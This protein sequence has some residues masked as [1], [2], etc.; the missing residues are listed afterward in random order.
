MYEYRYENPKCLDC[1]HFGDYKRILWNGIFL[2]Y[3]CNLCKEYCISEDFQPMNGV[4][5]NGECVRKK[6]EDDKIR[7]KQEQ[8]KKEREHEEKERMRRM[9]MEKEKD[10]LVF[11][12]CLF[13]FLLVFMVSMFVIIPCCML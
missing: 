4:N 11:D 1:E 6:I 5:I 7:M 3:W 13:L 9:Q 10:E 12:I 8:E 2:K